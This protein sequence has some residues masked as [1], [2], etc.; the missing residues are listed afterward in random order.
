M[1]ISF[2][3][4]NYSG[5]LKIGDLLQTVRHEAAQEMRVGPSESACRS[6]PYT[7][8]SALVFGR[9]TPLAL[10][11]LTLGLLCLN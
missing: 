8:A 3:Y 11:T 6:M 7:P 9:D 4:H 2:V 5:L 1:Q 10:L